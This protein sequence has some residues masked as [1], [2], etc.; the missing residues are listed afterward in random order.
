MR[1]D[2][3]STFQLGKDGLG[4]L[5]SK[6]DSPLIERVDV[7]DDPLNKDLVLIH[8]QERAQHER[9]ELLVNDGVGGPVPRESLIRIVCSVG[10]G[11]YWKKTEG[12]LRGD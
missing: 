11:A 7:P 2:F 8:G 12:G 4:K 5:L 1:S 9:R 10:F 3:A 6:L